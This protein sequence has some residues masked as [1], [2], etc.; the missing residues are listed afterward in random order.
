MQ[1]DFF[2]VISV[3]RKRIFREPFSESDRLMNGSFLSEMGKIMIL[4]KSG[5]LEYSIRSRCLNK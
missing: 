5:N 2:G 1:S 3:S 4:R